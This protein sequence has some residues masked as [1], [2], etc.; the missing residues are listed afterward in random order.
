MQTANSFLT[1]KCVLRL[2]PGLLFFVVIEDK[3]ME[4][5]KTVCRRYMA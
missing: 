3:G 1:G 5:V 2:I 4:K